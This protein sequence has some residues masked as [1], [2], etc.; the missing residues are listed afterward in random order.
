MSRLTGAC[1]L[2]SRRPGSHPRAVR[3][4]DPR[5]TGGAANHRFAARRTP[6]RGG[7][8]VKRHKAGVPVP[9]LNGSQKSGGVTGR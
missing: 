7:H 2:L 9:G 6:R 3:R 5:L 4:L 8:K 1:R